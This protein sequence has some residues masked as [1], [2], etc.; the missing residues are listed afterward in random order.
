MEERDPGRKACATRRND[1]GRIAA[2]A[3]VSFPFTT[4]K[5]PQ[6][7]ISGDTILVPGAQGATETQP[8]D[9]V[10]TKPAG[11]WSGT[12]HQ[13]GALMSSDSG[14]L[15]T[16]VISGPT[17]FAGRLEA[18]SDQT[19]IATG[20]AYV[21]TQPAAGWSGIVNE[22][23]KLSD[24]GGASVGSEDVYGKPS[25]GW[26]TGPPSA[27]LAPSGDPEPMSFSRVAV[28]GSTAVA[29]ALASGSAGSG[30]AYV[31]SR[32]SQGWSSA[33]PVG[34]L[35]DP[36]THLGPLAISGSIAAASAYPVSGTLPNT[37]R[38]DVFAEPAAGWSGQHNPAGNLVASDGA[39]LMAPPL[40]VN[41][42]GSR[43]RQQPDIPVRIHG[44]LRGMVRP[45]QR[46][47]AAGVPEHRVSASISID[48][49]NIVVNGV[50]SGRTIAALNQAYVYAEP[51]AGW[52][53]AV[54]ARAALTP[55]YTDATVKIY[56]EPAHGW[57]GTVHP[58]GRLQVPGVSASELAIDGDTV[59]VAGYV[60]PAKYDA[61]PCRGGVW[62]FSRPTAGW[63][64][65]L[66]AP[67]FVA[68]R[69]DYEGEIGL[70]LTGSMLFAGGQIIETSNQTNLDVFMVPSQV[71]EHLLRPGKPRLQRA[72]LSGLIT[73]R[74]K[75][76]FTLLA[77]TNAPPVRSLTISLPRGITVAARKLRR[78][79]LM[80]AGRVR[81]A[82]VRNGK[83]TI[84]L[85]APLSKA[86]L[87]LRW[88]TLRESATLHR[89]VHPRRK[90]GKH[91][92]RRLK[93][94]LTTGVSLV[95]ATGRAT[96]LTI[97]T[98]LVVRR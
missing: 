11:G 14:G 15:G 70:A 97:R 5:T 57:A 19:L 85:T 1:H 60:P 78:D 29:D 61:C 80:G 76:G 13:W 25:T 23:A 33:A 83:L 17:V 16:P 64:G 42:R 81:A 68:A 92:A 94:V 36:G 87:T 38:L 59:A 93:L 47:G 37:L 4:G 2:R 8:A 75:L 48:G 89:R 32:P 43:I 6:L 62:L 73:Q 31:F 51:A 90:A 71:T 88:P 34:T 39:S 84:N 56:R 3:S 79:A 7:A 28:S 74:P 20:S 30:A 63:A 24:P 21:F 40:T 58:S 50:I 54:P 26:T 86:S 9:F 41:D 82:T 10:F 35:V 96:K 12:E 52:G 77:G 98:R 53:A 69:S 49:G 66:A 67:E 22:T 55:D 45:D 44:A 91:T 18:V 95:D 46:D 72:A 27:T 65:T